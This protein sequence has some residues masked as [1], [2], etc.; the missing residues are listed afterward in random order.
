MIPLIWLERW[1]RR[2]PLSPHG[3]GH[4]A[5]PTT[6]RARG[7]R[8]RSRVRSERWSPRSVHDDCALPP[9]RPE[10]RHRST[11]GGTMFQHR[12]ASLCAGG[13]DIAADFACGVAQGGRAARR[14]GGFRAA[15]QAAWYGGAPCNRLTL[16]GTGGC[17]AVV[18]ITRQ[19]VCSMFPTRASFEKR[20]ARKRRPGC[21]AAAPAPRAGARRPGRR[22]RRSNHASTLA[23]LLKRLPS[24]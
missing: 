4:L 14:P 20:A 9:A 16:H 5:R 22:V 7:T 21:R 10:R 3:V 12:H 24:A 1:P 2:R 6:I 13:S 15:Y 8:S 17:H 19:R 23:A 11:T 18:E